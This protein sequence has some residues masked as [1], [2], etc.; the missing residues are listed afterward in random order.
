MLVGPEPWEPLVRDAF[1]VQLHFGRKLAEICDQVVFVVL[2]P[3]PAADTN[4]ARMT[5]G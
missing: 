4:T 3:N 1:G 5:D 2:N